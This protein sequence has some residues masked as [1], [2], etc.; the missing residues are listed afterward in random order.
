[1]NIKFVFKNN[2]VKT[3]KLKHEICSDKMN[4]K[5][6]RCC[7]MMNRTIGKV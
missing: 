3:V 2:K 7:Q 5:L 1:M 6:M 4:G